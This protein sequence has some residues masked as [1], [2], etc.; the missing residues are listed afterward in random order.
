MA[1]NILFRLEAVVVVECPLL[2][3]YKPY[4][5][6]IQDGSYI[7]LSR[8][9]QIDSAESHWHSTVPWRKSAATMAP[10]LGQQTA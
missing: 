8:T 1:C 9:C 5:V 2:G 3:Q 7:H 10:W 6:T 4:R